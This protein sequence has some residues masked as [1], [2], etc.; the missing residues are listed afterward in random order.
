VDGEFIQLEPVRQSSG[1]VVAAW[2]IEGDVDASRIQSARSRWNGRRAER[3]FV[4]QLESI[5]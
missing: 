3:G 5:S 2:A 4:D 1:K